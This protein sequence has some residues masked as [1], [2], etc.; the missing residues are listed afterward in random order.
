MK[1][2]IIAPVNS[3]HTV[4]WINSLVEKVTELHV[5][6]MHE[7]NDKINDKIIFHRLKFHPPL[8]YI[9]NWQELKKIIGLYNFD[10]IH[11]HYLSGYGT[12]SKLSVNNKMNK[13]IISMWGSDI[14]DFPQ[15]SFIHR[16][17][18]WWVTK[19]VKLI[20][21]TSHEMKKQY[22]RLYNLPKDRIKVVPFG[23]DIE[24]FSKELNSSNVGTKTKKDFVIGLAKN[25]ELRYGIK[26]LIEG[27]YQFHKNYP[28][29]KLHIIGDGVLLKDMKEIVK[30]LNMIEHIIFHGRKKN[31]ELR[32]FMRNWDVCVIPS[33]EESFGVAAVEAS[34]CSLPVIATNVGGLP[35]VVINNV[36]G[37]IISPESS[38][39]IALKL[40]YLYLN[41]DISKKLGKAGREIVEKK[42][43]WKDNVHTMY[44]LYHSLLL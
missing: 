2:L 4:R 5:V 29:S 14:Y 33:L 22:L 12:L 18:I 42:Y 6:S 9:F 1:L 20:T 37:L 10:V 31:D 26:F 23:V 19:D 35:E 25:I 43:N 8:G 21:S 28:L 34:A 11:T 39:E 27:F 38:E 24:L 15:R 32:D 40:E 7:L 17:L 13:H 41:P 30:K 16:K 3:I 44:E 36:S